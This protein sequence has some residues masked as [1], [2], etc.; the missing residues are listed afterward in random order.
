MGT[1]PNTMSNP[2]SAQHHRSSSSATSQT[3]PTSHREA[4]RAISR[5]QAVPPPE[6]PR[7]E[8]RY[9]CSRCERSF[10]DPSEVVR[11][12]GE[13]HGVADWHWRCEVCEGTTKPFERVRW[14]RVAEHCRDVHGQRKGQE[15]CRKVDGPPSTE[16]RRRA[17]KIQ[18]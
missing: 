7:P 14:H 16:P 13:W 11:H 1:N 18:R 6:R 9:P 2:S 17:N 5:E 8:L 3:A 12:L 4:P 10:H 15:R